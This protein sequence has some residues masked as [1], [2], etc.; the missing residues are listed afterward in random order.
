MAGVE[1]GREPC[2]DRILDD[3]GGAYGMGAVGGGIWHLGRGLYNSPSGRRLRGGYEAV[4]M[5]SPTIGSSFAIWGGLFSLS[6]CTLGYIR[7]K[8]DPW[9]SI[10][11]GAI[12]GGVL[13]LRQGPGAAARSAMVGGVLLAIIEGV[14]IMITRMS[15]PQPAAP[16]ELDDPTLPAPNTQPAAPQT[17]AARTSGSSEMSST[18]VTELSDKYEASTSIQTDTEAKASKGF[19][20]SVWGMIG[21]GGDGESRTGKESPPESTAAPTIP[22]FGFNSDAKF[23]TSK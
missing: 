15:A 22:D 2:P 21:G 4:R 6:D 3:I 7:K 13:Q 10:G 1:H 20:G 14:G 16:V 19:F 8:E 18:T 9:N 11:A 17:N 5:N 23:A 12:T